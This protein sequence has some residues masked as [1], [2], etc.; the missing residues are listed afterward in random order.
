MRVIDLADEFNEEELIAKAKILSEATGRDYEDVLEDLLD[1]GKLN[2]SN[3]SKPDL[4]EQLKEAAELI[5]TVQSISQEVADNSVLNGGDNKTEVKVETT[6]EG[7]VVDRAIAS[8]QRKADDMKKLIATLI[9]VFLL[10]TGGSMEAFGITN[11]FGSDSDDNDDYYVEVGGCMNPEA[12]NYNPDAD[13]ED[14]TCNFGGP[15]GNGTIPPPCESDWIWTD[16][17]IMDLDDDGQGFNNDLIIEA[18]F[19]DRSQC[20][21]HMDNGY[22]EVSIDGYDEYTIDDKFHDQYRI[23]DMYE[24]LPAGD[25]RVSID[26]HTNDGSFWEGPSALITMEEE[27]YEPVYGCTD[28]SATNYNDD[29]DEDD[30]S[31]TYPEPEVCNQVYLYDIQFTFTNDSAQVSFDLD[32]ENEEMREVGVSF[33]VVPRGGDSATEMAYGYYNITGQEGDVH[34]LELVDFVEENISYYDFY[35]YAVWIDE[36]DQYW[37][38]YQE[39]K[40]VEFQQE[41]ETI[42]CDDTKSFNITSIS[43]TFVTN[44]SNAIDLKWSFEHD[45]PDGQACWDFFQIEIALY[46]DGAFYDIFQFSESDWYYASGES[47]EHTI[48][49]DSVSMFTNLSAGEYDALLKYWEDGAQ[50]PSQD[51]FTNKIRIL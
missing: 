31:C 26:Y 8:V 32:C 18:T 51:I 10:L 39:R 13:F 23:E 42:S 50:G 11:F 47:V 36:D 14:G 45:G 40:G 7:D 19:R 30:G 24:N 12:L 43:A 25:Y 48:T 35:W 28:P 34:T 3:I 1:D 20:N 29:A 2:E 27:P 15:N 4:V 9:P 44:G 41:T 22:F 46:K 6:L 17:L 38:I 21:R 37:E 5:T 16:V 49:G 33:Y